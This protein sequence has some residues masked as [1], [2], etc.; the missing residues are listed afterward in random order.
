MARR[1]GGMA[2][3]IAL[4]LK[5]MPAGVYTYGAPRAGAEGFC[6][7]YKAA[8]LA[9]RTFR[10]VHGHDIVP[11]VPPMTLG[12]QHAG[13]CLACERHGRFDASRLSATARD[14]SPFGPQL[15]DGLRAGLS[16]LR[17][18][19][20]DPKI[21]PDLLGL[22]SRGLAP[23]IGDHLPDRYWRALSPP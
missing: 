10:I 20:W 19:S 5:I 2:E 15:L 9:T 13:R 8:G 23:P 17:S 6:K 4:E 18:G 1:A 12:F 22:A 7:A 14:E 3:R 16:Q 21:R 11:T